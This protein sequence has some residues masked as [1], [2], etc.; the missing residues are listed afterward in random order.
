M[1]CSWCDKLVKFVKNK[2]KKGNPFE[3]FLLIDWLFW[4]YAVS[5]MF[6]PY[7]DNQACSGEKVGQTEIDG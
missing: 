6:Q 5:V 2:C 4:Y 1:F 7:N 3:F